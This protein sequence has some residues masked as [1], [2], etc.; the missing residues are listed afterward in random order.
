MAE[1]LEIVIPVKLDSPNWLRN[2][3][4]SARNKE[5]KMWQAAIHY[6]AGC[7]LTTWTLKLGE[8]STLDKR[9][10][11]RFVELRKKER[12]RVT[13]IR[14][15]ASR[16]EFMQDDDN[17]KF[18]LKPVNDALKRLGLLFQDSRKW[19]EQPPVDQQVSPDGRPYTIIRIER[20][21]EATSA[22]PSAA[23]P[24]LPVIQ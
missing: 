4:W 10:H 19:L 18:A 20:L 17:L 14:Q 9:G 8:K 13:V 6:S 5:T 12:R 21:S 23:I 1:V 24:S 16:R 7:G 22:A 11:Y 15:V 2:P 3:H